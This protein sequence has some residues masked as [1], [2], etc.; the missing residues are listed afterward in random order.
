MKT[1]LA[2]LRRLTFAAV[3]LLASAAGVHAQFPLGTWDCVISEKQIG[4]A[5]IQFDAD[6]TFTGLQLMR[7]SSTTAKAPDVNPRYVGG[8]PRREGQAPTAASTTS[9]NSIFVGGTSLGGRWGY[10]ESGRVIGLLDQITSR[11]EAVTK[12][13][14]NIVDGTN[15][16]FTTNVFELVFTT[17]AVS[18]RGSGVAGQRLTIASYL[19]DGKRNIY[20]G[21][22]AIVRPDQTGDFFATGTRGSIPLV[23]F[24]NFTPS[25]GYP[26]PNVYR[27]TGYG[28]GYGLGGYA[29][30]SRSGRIAVYSQTDR[31]PFT[32]TVH[33]GMYNA[34]TRKGTIYGYDSAGKKYTYRLVHQ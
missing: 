3:A 19:P 27:T 8:E 33:S 28:A 22:P 21:T 14:T 1:P 6:F 15:F 34:T 26:F 10:D 25:L 5:V 4:L 13:I 31:D 12:S 32:I 18:F 20:R 9:S 7:P 23:E 30:V 29:I 24:L 16:V 17:N 11:I 2:Y